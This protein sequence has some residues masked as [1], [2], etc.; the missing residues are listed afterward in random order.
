M[1]KVL[2]DVSL[3]SLVR[4]QVGVKKTESVWAQCKRAAA[5]GC[6]PASMRKDAGI[7]SGPVNGCKLN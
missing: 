2:L 7:R 1:Q 6:A 3:A 4:R 5:T